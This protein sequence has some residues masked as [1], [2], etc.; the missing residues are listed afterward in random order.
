MTSSDFHAVPVDTIVIQPRQRKTVSSNHIPTL[1]ESIRNVGLINPIVITRDHVLVAGECRLTAI[2]DILGWTHIPAQYQDEV[3]PDLLHLIEL[4]ENVKREQLTWQDQNDAITEYHRLLAARNPVWSQTKTAEAAG[5]SQQT[6]QGHLLVKK[7]MNNPL[8]RE[9]VSYKTALNT[10]RRVEER[11][12]SDELYAHKPFV[13]THESPVLQADFNTWAPAYN[14]P[15]FNLIHCDFPYGIDAHRMAGQNSALAVEYSD[16]SEDFAQLCQTL[17]MHLDRVCAPSA[18]MIFWFPTTRYSQTLALLRALD[19]FRWEEV[20]LIWQRGENE[21]IAPDPARRP[22]RVYE[23]AFFGWRN[24]RKIIR[25]KANSIV[26]P[27]ERERHPHEKSEAALLH[28]FGM[29]VD[30]ETRLLDPTC[31]SGS[32]L[33]AAKALGARTVLGLES[34]PTYAEDAR[35]SLGG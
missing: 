21:G 26:A 28:F 30:G 18:H 5:V 33:R 9:A 1:A 17:I 8:V 11:L 32:A 35:R 24:D 2:R 25:T 20:P 27:T 31:G 22:R 19:G 16:T 14:G 7:H 23:M 10:A 6:V 34:N 4:E 3:D 13:S 12:A 29:C 15:R